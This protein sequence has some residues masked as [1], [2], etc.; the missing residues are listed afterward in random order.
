MYK[1]T[2][3]RRKGTAI[4]VQNLRT[5]GGQVSQISWK[6]AHEGGKFV[7]PMHQ[8]PLPRRK[9]SWYSFLLETESAPGPQC[10]RKD[11]VYEKYIT[12]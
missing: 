10:G 11:Y 9:Y 7:I 12:T 5:P 3:F 1:N 4:A 6:S 8:P 2:V